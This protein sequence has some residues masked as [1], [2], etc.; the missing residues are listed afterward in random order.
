M[1]GLHLFGQAVADLR[2]GA[3]L[4][5]RQAAHRGKVAFNTWEK[6]GNGQP[7][8]D[9]EYNAVDMAFGLPSGTALVAASNA[10]SPE[11]LAEFTAKARSSTPIEI[12]SIRRL[13]VKPGETLVVRVDAF[14]HEDQLAQVKAAVRAELPDGV[15]VLVTNGHVDMFVVARDGSEVA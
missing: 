6:I 4:S 7:V 13:D 11:K 5:A 9:Q 12:E 1:A 8:E 2:T 10:A 14:V 3:G 15:H